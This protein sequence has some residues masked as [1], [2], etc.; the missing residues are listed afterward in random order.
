ML[1]YVGSVLV[2]L[3]MDGTGMGCFVFFL[4]TDISPHSVPFYH[5]V[6]AYAIDEQATVAF[7]LGSCF[8]F[9]Q[10][11]PACKGRCDVVC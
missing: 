6:R 3:P 4:R 1:N 9:R 5:Y 10:N 7:M 11:R 2:I 8:Q